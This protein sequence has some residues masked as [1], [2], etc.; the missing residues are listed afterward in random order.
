MGPLITQGLIDPHWDLLIALLIGIAFGYILEASGFSSSRKIAGVFYGY[1]FTVLRVF[2]TATVVAMLGLVYFNYMAWIDLDMIFVLP[3]Y[4]SSMLV[5][6]ILMAFGFVMG[7]YCPGTSFTGLVIGKTDALVFL[8]GIVLGIFIFSS[9]FPLIEDIYYG[10]DIGA[11]TIQET[12]GISRGLF[13][14]LL[15]IVTI[16]VFFLASLVKTRVKQVEL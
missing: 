11:A 8:G 7:G 14:F 1:D 10:G 6:G 16:I 3:T 12:L 5:G 9:I 2:M 15:V 4:K 13:A